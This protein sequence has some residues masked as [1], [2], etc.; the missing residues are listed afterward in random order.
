MTMALF[1]ISAS[2]V[3]QNFWQTATIPGVNKTI[4]ALTV[5]GSGNVYAATNGKGLFRSSDGGTSWLRI[6]S[7]RSDPSYDYCVVIN[8]ASVWVGTYLGNAWHSTDNGS[9]WNK[10][11]IDSSAGSIITSFAYLPN[12]HILASTGANGMFVS[13]DG[14][15]TWDQV[16]I[17]GSIGSNLFQIIN[18]EKGFLYV[19]TYGSGI[20]R[21]SPEN[22]I[23]D[24]TGLAG[25]RI[26]GFAVNP[27]GGLFAAT[28]AGV[29]KDST[30]I[31]SV[32]TEKVDNVDKTIYDTT[33]AW[34]N[35]QSTLQTSGD[36]LL[37]LAFVSSVISTP[38]GHLLASTVGRGVFHSSNLGVTWDNVNTGIVGSDIRTLA[39][40][41][42]GYVY[43]GSVTGAVYKS[44]QPEPMQS[45][46]PSQTVTPPAP[47]AYV[48]EQN[49]PNPFNPTT[50][51]PFAMP[52]AGHASI[53][54]YNTLGEVVATVLDQEMTAGPHT[55]RW[56]A[57][58]VPSGIYFYRFQSGSFSRSGKL[59]LLK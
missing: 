10:V 59:V 26:N 24:Y 44:T 30:V 22:L 18:D 17:A 23:W 19:A 37:H 53:K 15:T 48:L 57:S 45:I 42:S 52:V 8:G 1:T 43:C 38:G 49:Y 25:S 54:I 33:V 6:D 47:K 36:T 51:I 28:D 11:L 50:N 39:L 21:S 16:Q 29:F 7:T 41:A 32:G 5:D 13:A 2:A 56:D 9:S 3:A 27:Q 58:F 20:Y 46:G 34:R 14:G 31:D 12:G 40:D 35:V 55:V 4:N